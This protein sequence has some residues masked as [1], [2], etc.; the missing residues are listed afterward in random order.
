MF[1]EPIRLL[2]KIERNER[3]NLNLYGKE[4]YKIKAVVIETHVGNTVGT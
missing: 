3:A 4:S 1:Q 2:W